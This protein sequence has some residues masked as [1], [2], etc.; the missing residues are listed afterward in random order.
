MRLT[1]LQRHFIVLL[2]VLLLLF[3]QQQKNDFASGDALRPHAD[4]AVCPLLQHLDQLTGT[5]LQKFR[6]PVFHWHDD[7][8]SLLIVS[9]SRIAFSNTSFMA[10]RHCVCI[11][12]RL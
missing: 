2:G 12:L 10:F 1:P 6:P 9:N 7:F 3:C 4:A 11:P 5:V 8:L